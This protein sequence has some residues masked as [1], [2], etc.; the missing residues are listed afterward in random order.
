MHRAEPIR[1]ALAA[2]A[3]ACLVTAAPAAA[4]PRVAIA[5]GRLGEAVIALAAQTGTDIGLRDQRL[6]SLRVRGVTGEMSAEQALAQMLRDAPAQAVRVGANMWVVVP[7]RPSA[8]AKPRGAPRPQFASQRPQPAP[9]PV[10]ETSD[11]VDI[12]VTAT[13]R[14]IRFGNLSGLATVVGGDDFSPVPDGA[15][16]NAIASRAASV[17][18]THF[19]AGRNKLFIRGIADSAFSGPTQ[20]TVGQYLGEARTSYSAPDPDLR[21]HD[22]KAIEIL[23]GPQGTIFGAGSLGGIV[24]AVPAEPEFDRLGGRMIATATFTTGGSPGGEAVLI[25]NIPLIADTAAL[26]ANVYRARE[27]GYIDDISR[28]RTDLNRSDIVGGRA[29]LAAKLGGG[30]TGEA[31]GAVQSIDTRDAQYADRRMPGL[32]RRNPFDQPFAQRFVLGNATLKGPVGALNFTGTFGALSNRTRE[33]FDASTLFEQE[34]P[35]RQGNT[36]SLLA[37]EARLDYSGSD[38]W[39]T[40]AGVSF[41]RNRSVGDREVLVKNLG[42]YSASVQSNVTEWTLF[43]EASKRLTTRLTATLGGR[44]SAIHLY[45]YRHDLVSTEDVISDIAESARTERVAAP[46]AALLYAIRPDLQAFVRYQQGYRPGGISIEFGRITKFSNDRLATFELGLRFGK[47][48]RS[49]V[50]GQMSLSVSRWSDIQADVADNIGLPITLNIGNGKIT[51]ASA[52]IA[53]APT[54]RFGL[55]AGLVYNRSRLDEPS[56]RLVTF[57]HAIANEVTQGRAT[58]PNVTDFSARVAARFSGDFGGRWS[59]DLNGAIRYIGLSRLGLGVR[60]N[61]NQGGYTQTNLVGRLHHDDLTLFVAINNLLD[62]K[63]S[64]FGVG[65]PFDLDLALQYVPQ[66]PRSVSVGVDLAF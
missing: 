57:S 17:T 32:G 16:G 60:F 34:A 5:P 58:L 49:V 24:K 64:R 7:M 29:I 3:L 50:S 15:N 43:A 30:W 23:E 20:S 44:V 26:R 62:D 13:K 21:L 48:Q 36:T 53:F 2:T 40:L 4:Q 38:G 45:G 55:E 28:N 52:A 65:N 10:P 51:T 22:L 25:G 6:A 18:S 33:V 46:S 63:A 11:P 41:L 35:Y 8:R 31:M 1:A 42:Q 56:E 66:R 39:S 59:W 9:E 61:K 54:P 47:R 14:Q 19:G 27:G 12:V 37:G